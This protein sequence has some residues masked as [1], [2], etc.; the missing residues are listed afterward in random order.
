MTWDSSATR[1]FPKPSEIKRIPAYQLLFYVSLYQN[2]M[3]AHLTHQL[4]V[5]QGHSGSSIPPCWAA[6]CRPAFKFE[7][8]KFFWAFDASV[9]QLIYFFVSYK[10]YILPRR[11]A[12]LMQTCFYTTRAVFFTS[13]SLEGEVRL[14]LGTSR[15]ELK[16]KGKAISSFDALIYQDR[17][18]FILSILII[19]ILFE[20][21]TLFCIQ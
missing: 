17:K 20:I 2:T 11:I 21:P 19:H 13:L 8:H 12:D 9:C 18:S 14:L 5:L 6:A 7:E 16:S 4:L 10:F 3:L 15:K 1:V